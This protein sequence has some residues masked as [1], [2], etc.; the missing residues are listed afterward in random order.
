MITTINSNLR[1]FMIQSYDLHELSVKI[2]E[3]AS[4]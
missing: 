1:V 4:N 2:K 3:I